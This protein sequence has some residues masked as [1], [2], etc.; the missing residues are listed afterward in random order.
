MGYLK[1]F[2]KLVEETAPTKPYVQEAKE[3][4]ITIDINGDDWEV[5]IIDGTHIK[6]KMKG[7]KVWAIPLHFQQVSDDMM[8]ALKKKGVVKDNFFKE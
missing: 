5:V 3:K 1:K 6:F 4:I 7:M 8:D 2:T